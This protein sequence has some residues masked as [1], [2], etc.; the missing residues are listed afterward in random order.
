MPV[1]LSACKV[2]QV[3]A[4]L[5]ACAYLQDALETTLSSAEVHTLAA[6]GMSVPAPLDYGRIK[7]HIR[8]RWCNIPVE[9]ALYHMNHMHMHE[10][11]VGSRI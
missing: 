3:L 9:D 11:H 1:Q 6:A 4:C 8:V 7:A 5:Y 2:A 10:I